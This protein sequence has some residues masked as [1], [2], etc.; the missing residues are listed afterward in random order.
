[1]GNNF[2]K[3]LSLEVRLFVVENL[4]LEDLLRMRLICKSWYQVFCDTKV[5]AHAIKRYFPFPL[6]YYCHQSSLDSKGVEED[7]IRGKWL[8]KFIINRIRRENGIASH[9]YHL[10]YN[11]DLDISKI[12]YYNGRIVVKKDY[13][14]I[15]QD[16][17]TKKLFPLEHPC[18]LV[19]KDK[20]HVSDRYLIAVYTL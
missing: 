5:C 18:G 14:F 7:K 8:Q 9:T 20:W 13:G 6:D 2:F 3:R 16:L 1:M 15:V 17:V 4:Y 19:F 10:E 12:G 11:S